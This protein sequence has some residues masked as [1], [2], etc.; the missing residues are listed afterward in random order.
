MKL[1]VSD[2]Q[3]TLR[4][5]P[6]AGEV[7]TAMKILHV[8][9]SDMRRSPRRHLLQ[10]AGYTVLEATSGAEA[11]QLT[12][13]EQPDLVVLVVPLPDMSGVEFY[14]RLKHDPAMT[15]IV[16]VQMSVLARDH[17]APALT[18][19][20]GADVYLHASIPSEKFMATIKTLLRLRQTETL[21]QQVQERSAAEEALRHQQADLY[22]REKLTVMGAL[23][24]SVAHELNNPL[25]VVQ[26]QVDLLVE[27][28]QDRFLLERV[29]ELQH[30]TERCR[31]MVQNFLTLAHY[32]PPQRTLVQL[33][34]A[35]TETLQMLEPALHSDAIV[36][37]QYLD[38]ALPLIGA[39]APQ[40]QQMILH[41]LRNAQQALREISTSRQLI[42]TTHYDPVQARVI[43]EVADTGP[44]IPSEMQ[45]RIFEPF[46]TTKPVG[47]GT[48]L[49]LSICRGIIAG[50]GG[51]VSVTSQPGY[52]AVFRI[53]LPVA[54][55]PA[56]NMPASEASSPPVKPVETLLIVDDEIGLARGLARLL[57]RD[58]YSVDTATNGRQ[59]LAMLETREYHLLLCDLRMPELDGPGLYQAV[60]SRWPHLLSRFI[61]LTGD[62]LSPDTRNFL[63]QTGRPC[64][65]KPFTAA[66]GRR[67]VWQALQAQR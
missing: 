20:E 9:D 46:F 11:L 6:D 31:R 1:C 15:A 3:N 49:G 4:Q 45:G 22:Q 48:G 44:G 16:V 23:L 25:A 55:A 39:D 63:E 18:Q 7:R 32:S 14:R 17:S 62:A 26:M 52:G 42:L 24:A 66:E 2:A 12:R 64:L 13:A 19:Q 51:T 27:D 54:G 58:G 30:A 40:L 67:V 5:P 10:R 43:L 34:A 37:H 47:A 50:H 59:A 29:T 36:V 57:R 60:A 61:F 28:T 38:D 56:P 8:D 33:N 65:I 53:E 41:L 21:L 35:I